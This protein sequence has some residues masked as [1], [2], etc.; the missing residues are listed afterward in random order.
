MTLAVPID[1]DDSLIEPELNCQENNIVNFCLN[2]AVP[3]LAV[4][5]PDVSRLALVVLSPASTM[6]LVVAVQCFLTSSTAWS[7]FG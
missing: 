3:L 7:C 2:D 6:M 5:E 4:D 1:D